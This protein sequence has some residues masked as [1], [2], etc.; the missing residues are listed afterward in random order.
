MFFGTSNFPPTAIFKNIVE[1]PHLYG[2]LQKYIK[3][4]SKPIF[5]LFKC[6]STGRKIQWRA[7]SNKFTVL[8]K[9][10]Y[11]QFC[12]KPAH[13]YHLCD[14][15]YHTQV[16]MS[17]AVWDSTPGG[18]INQGGLGFKIKKMKFNTGIG[19]AGLLVG[20]ESLCRR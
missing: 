15:V 12:L 20:N 10:Y 13:L 17:S 1:G 2:L 7:V 19:T 14:R 16:L 3:G 5:C 18:A 8:L 9:K 4:F 6:I 11:T